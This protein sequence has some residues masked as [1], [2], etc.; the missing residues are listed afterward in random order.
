MQSTFYEP[1]INSFHT[2]IIM[3]GNGRWASRLGL[4]RFDGHREGSKAVRRT[5]E[6]A[7]PLG[8]TVL[9]LYAFSSDNWRRP[10]TEVDR[11]M[12][13][14]YDYLHREKITCLEN[15]I[16]LNVIGRRDRLSPLLRAAIKATETATAFGGAMLLRI[17]IDY[18]S[19][20]S[21]LNAALRMNENDQT[22][23]A[24]ARALADVNHAVGYV[25]DVD[26][27]IRTGGEKRLSDFLL[28]ESA[29]AEL[30][31]CEKMWPDFTGADLAE[32][33]EAYRQR[34]RRFGA[35]PQVAVNS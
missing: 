11:L 3:D 30:H 13:I 25:P 9:T 14:F 2:A 24:F 32:A 1:D 20:D 17:A 5:V 31:F 8:I 19:R 28:W 18:S 6:A 22:D 27:L 16:R 15:G 4:P 10:A 29:Y 33:V 35:V 26:L 12:E 34:D 21:I 7:P 23:K